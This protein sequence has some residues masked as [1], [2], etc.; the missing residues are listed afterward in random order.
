[1]E[2][3]TGVWGLSQKP[4]SDHHKTRVKEVRTMYVEVIGLG[5]TRKY[6]IPAGSTI[7]TLKEKIDNTALDTFY[8][9]GEVVDDDVVL[10]EG[11]KI[12]AKEAS[13]KIDLG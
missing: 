2:F 1:M 4:G 9:R 12:V 7:A 11:D 13:Q 3:K 10:E 8:I 6:S 5:F